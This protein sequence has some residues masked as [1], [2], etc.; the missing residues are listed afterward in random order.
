MAGLLDFFTGSGDY[1]DP[2][3]ID[4]RYG[5]PMSDVR[6]AALNSIG[7]MGAI[8]M[9]AGQRMEPAQ[10]AAYLAQ[11]GQAGAGFNTDLYN[12]AQRR[13]MQ[14][15]Y[16]TKMDDLK[17]DAAIREQ[18]KDPAAFKAK[19]GFDPTGMRPAD[20]RGTMRTIA[21]RDPNAAIL[22]ALS[23]KEK[24]RSLNMPKTF[25]SGGVTYRWD[26]EKQ[27]A[28]PLT[29][30]KTTG[31]LEGEDNAAILRGARDPDFAKTP[32]YATAFSRRYGPETVIRNGEVVQI[33]KPIPSGIPRPAG[34]DTAAPASGAPGAGGET[35]TITGPG[36]ASV[37][38]T[39]TQPRTLSAAEVALRGET[40]TLLDGLRSAETALAD[41]ER[42]SKKAFSGLGAAQRAGV[43]GSTG[44]DS[45]ASVATREFSSIMTEQAL[46]QLR[47][48]FGGNPTEGERKILLEMQA[49]VNMSQPQREALIA[50]ARKAVEARKASVERRLNEI[51]SGKYNSIQQ[52]EEQP[53][54]Q[55]RGVPGLPPGFE[56]IR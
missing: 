13:L 44:V 4:P 1:A 20:V 56:V 48:I 29:P 53:Q 11:L 43:M 25:E 16:A 46:S 49:S 41:A 17:E 15:Q 18:M 2:E 24:T 54:P 52:V 39:S 51:K 28:V 45:E 30:A 3:K 37:S 40:E 5:V 47:A 9:A 32:E 6:Q 19:Y 55:P 22:T 23:I 12:A 21:A 42:L 27:Q 50:R 35:R 10:R 34:F 33:V 7:N 26:E 14:S 8:L 31:G 36:G 38:V